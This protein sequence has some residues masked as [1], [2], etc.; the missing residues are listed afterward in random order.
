LPYRYQNGTGIDGAPI[1]VSLKSGKP[2]ARKV[3]HST[4]GGDYFRILLAGDYDMSVTVNG[5]SL[6]VPM[7]IYGVEALVVNFVVLANSSIVAEFQG[8]P[9]WPSP[10]SDGKSIAPHKIT[11][12]VVLGCVGLLIL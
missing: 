9:P 12:V 8:R 3:V 2:G 10:L 4:K 7:H 6:T 11:W 1:S 5:F